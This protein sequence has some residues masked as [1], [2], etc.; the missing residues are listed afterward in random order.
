MM[1]RK[2]R[3]SRYMLD[4]VAGWVGYGIYRVFFTSLDRCSCVKLDTIDTV[5]P[6]RRSSSP[7]SSRSPAPLRT[8]MSWPPAAEPVTMDAKRAMHD[9]STSLPSTRSRKITTSQQSSST[10]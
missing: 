3:R 5:V 9:H 1:E 4:R 10:K 8:V 7:L 6:A 2:I